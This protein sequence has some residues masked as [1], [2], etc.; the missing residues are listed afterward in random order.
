[1]ARRRL[2]LEAL[3][4]RAVPATFG[5]PWPNP[6]HLTLSFA[7]DG[8]S[9]G[10]QQSQLFTMLDAVAP[11]AVWQG[12][13]AKAF[14]TWA[15]TTNVNVSVVG[16][17]GDPLGTVGP[18]QGDSR[19]GDLRVVAVP[20]PSDVLG[21]AMPFDVSSGSWAGDVELNSNALF[22]LGGAPGSDLFSVALHEAGHAL[23]IDGNS[24]PASPMFD[25]LSSPHTSLT[26]GD[27]ASIQSLYGVRKADVYDAAS[28]NG[29]LTYAT[30]INLSL[31]GNG[32]SPVLI[33]AN[34]SGPADSDFYA[35]RPVSSE[36]SM[37][38]L[39]QTSGI[40]ML[41]PRVTVYSSTQAVLASAEAADPLHGDLSVRVANLI[42]GATYYIRVSGA[43]NDVFG[44]GAYRLQILP[45]GAAPVT[46]GV[47]GVMTL[48]NDA[49]TNDTP[50][51]A[52][53]LRQTSFQSDSR[54]AYACQA[55][56]TDSTDVDYYRL[57]SPQGANG[58]TTVMRVLVWGTQ[59]GGLDPAVTVTDSHGNV[60]PADVLVNEN[61]SFVLQVPNALPNTDYYVAV[62]GEHAAT[63][64]AVGGY[65]LGV[66][67]SNKAVSLPTLASGTLSADVRNAFGGIQVTQSQLFHLALAASGAPGTAVQTILYDQ[68]GAIVASLTAM[69]GET[70]TLTVFLSPG[71]Y[72]VRF[73]Q[74][75]LSGVPLTPT[76]YTLRGIGLSDPIGPQPTD[77][78]LTP[79]APSS[80]NTTTTQPDLGYY[81][82]TTGFA[83]FLTSPNQT[84]TG[85]T[86]L[87]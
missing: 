60:I 22:S 32:L 74:G 78:T 57:R 65:F 55:A 41:R 42:P 61:G 56:I 59:V 81:W 66:D 30:Q 64:H 51:T 20:L 23:G 45:N 43:S 84:M 58:T 13:I 53:D 27:L 28:S 3:E 67:F 34:V 24:D 85:S 36:T 49:H 1:M 33:D 10:G 47:T 15:A 52:T 14:Q 82:L 70:Q 48:P 18:I 68:S 16:D 40:S 77:P 19:F 62:R 80:T 12:A 17:S 69:S 31:G 25:S 63:G 72:T 71:T 6:G 9:V 2:F 86:L 29:A 79:I 39:V 50:G 73:V 44:A 35:I 46:G 5:I 8:T 38:V 26:A 4:D 11:T 21:F 37:T 7:P 87:F 54:Y 83:P 75:G 76:T